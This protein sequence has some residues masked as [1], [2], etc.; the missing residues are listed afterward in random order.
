M[1]FGVPL[2]QLLAFCPLVAEMPVVALEAVAV[3][4]VEVL[5][6]VV[7]MKPAVV[8]VVESMAAKVVLEVGRVVH[9]RWV[10]GGS[11]VV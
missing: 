1:L 10:G 5:A 3:A 4:A 7:M 8:V 6:V 9:G 11:R 2:P